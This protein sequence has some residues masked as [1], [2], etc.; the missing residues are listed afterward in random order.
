M[1]K[2]FLVLLSTLNLIGCDDLNFDKPMGQAMPLE[3]SGMRAADQKA[4]IEL[5]DEFRRT[6]TQMRPKDCQDNG[7]KGGLNEIV[8]KRSETLAPYGYKMFS[9]WRCGPTQNEL[10]EKYCTVGQLRTTVFC[11]ALK[12]CKLEQKGETLVYERTR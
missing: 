2:P 9:G 3:K 6:C 12:E 5:Q 10:G 8:K 7:T 4:I 1:N 11:P